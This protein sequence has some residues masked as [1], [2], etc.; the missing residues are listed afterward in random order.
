[1]ID[2]KFIADGFTRLANLLGQ[3]MVSQ[4]ALTSHMVALEKKQRE[5]E[6]EVK[7]LRGGK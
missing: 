2:L 7:R 6:Q 4:N 5:L 1:M 3:V